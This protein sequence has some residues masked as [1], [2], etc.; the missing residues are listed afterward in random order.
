MR[1]V[2]VATVLLAVPVHAQE[3]EPSSL[4]DQTGPVWAD[5]VAPGP[6]D[7]VVP[8]AEE[9]TDA[10]DEIV[11]PE[12][13]EESS[14][15]PDQTGPAWVD[16]VAA[17]SM[18]QVIPVAEEETDAGDEI[19]APEATEVELLAQQFERFKKLINDGVYDEADTV[20][21]RAVELA[22]QV[23]GPG[24]LVTAKALTNLAIAQ[25]RN[26]QYDPAQ[27]NFQAAVEIIEELEDRLSVNLVNP[28]RG[29]GA[30]QL[31]AGRPDLANSTFRRAVHVTHVNEGPHNLYQIEL[32]QSLAEVSLMLGD[33][34]EAKELQDRMYMLNVRQYASDTMALVPPLIQRAEWQHRAGMIVDER[35]TYRRVIRIIEKNEGKDDTRL[36]WPLIA[37]GRSFGYPDRTGSADFQESSVVTGE[38][39]FKRALRI[40]QANPESGWEL[41]ANAML[42]LGDYYMHIGNAN[43]GRKTYVSAWNMLSEDEARLEFRRQRLERTVLLEERL[44]PQYVSTPP[45]QPALVETSPFLPATLTMSYAVSS[46]GRVTSLKIVEADPPEFTDMHRAIER[47]LRARTY[48]PRYEE[49]KPTETSNQLLIHTFYYRQADLD[50]LRPAVEYVVKPQGSEEI[51]DGDAG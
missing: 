9:E 2:V 49:A 3:E 4:P 34:D 39:Y 26:M 14:S 46:R 42:A 10:G 12:A 8:V 36:V 51:S 29:L 22:I 23:T 37:Y 11:A 15:L 47:S 44:L 13:T 43:R 41:R 17:G 24:S 40:A 25:D 28:L 32:L 27:Q 5:E 33:T 45:A 19:V 7:Q 16:E 31:K 38:I 35:A 30:T 50:A 18:G 48:R 6:M 21:K 20:A 1:V